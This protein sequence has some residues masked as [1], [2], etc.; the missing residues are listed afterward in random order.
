MP[1]QQKTGQ[2]YKIY[3]MIPTNPA[4]RFPKKETDTGNE[5]QG[6][7]PKQ[8]PIRL[9]ARM[10]REET[11]HYNNAATSSGNKKQADA[12]IKVFELDNLMTVVDQ[13][14]DNTVTVV[15]YVTH[16][17][18]HSG[19]KCFIVGESQKVTFQVMAGGEIESFNRE[20]EGSKLAITGIIKEERLSQEYIDEVEGKVNLKEQAGTSHEACESERNNIKSM[21]EWM[22]EHN[23]DYYAIYYMEGIKF[24]V[25]E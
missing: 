5:M 12:S 1:S 20:L 23:K 18:K 4:I 21:R 13:E 11:K 17:C 15:G 3:S 19:R 6:M 8:I 22:K 7:K 24:E 9:N 14:L 25:L 2:K 16:T 10:K